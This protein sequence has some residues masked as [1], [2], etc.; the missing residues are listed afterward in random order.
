MARKHHPQREQIIRRLQQ[1]GAPSVSVISQETKIPKPTLYAWLQQAKS[2]SFKSKQ[3]T[4]FLM[5]KKK[6][7][8]TTPSEKMNIVIQA[9]S[10]SGQQ[11]LDFCSSKGVTLAELTSWRDQALSGLELLGQPDGVVP[12]KDF[13]SLKKEVTRKNEALAEA[14]ALIL[15]QKKTSNLL[16]VQS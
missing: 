14:S 1:P 7:K 5:T 2:A 16:S 6:A 3:N 15:L 4:G 12:R 13:E 11:L 9:N 10:L 8:Q